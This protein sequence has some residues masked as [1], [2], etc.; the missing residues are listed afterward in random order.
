MLAR[1]QKRA[2]L[3]RRFRRLLGFLQKATQNEA[4]VRQS[5]CCQVKFLPL[6]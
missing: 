2:E 1:A 6:I 3:F 5:F 4:E